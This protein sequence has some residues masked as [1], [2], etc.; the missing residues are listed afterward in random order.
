MWRLLFVSRLLTRLPT[1]SAAL[2]TVPMLIILLLFRGVG[3]R[4]GAGVGGSVGW[5]GLVGRPA[6]LV[7]GD[8]AS[9]DQS[10]GPS[11]GLIGRS[12]G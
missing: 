7:G 3:F 2:N 5:L 12:V 4:C 10:I 9:V 1:L 6:G 11:V 8:V